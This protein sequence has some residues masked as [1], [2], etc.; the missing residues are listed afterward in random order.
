MG[1]HKAAGNYHAA[2]LIAHRYSSASQPDTGGRTN[3]QIRELQN[4]FRL[5]GD[6]GGTADWRTY[7]QSW[8]DSWN[9]HRGQST[10]TAKCPY[11]S[12]ISGD[13]ASLVGKCAWTDG[14]DDIFTEWST[15]FPIS[16]GSSRGSQKFTG[17]SGKF[18]GMSVLRAPEGPRI[19]CGCRSRFTA[20]TATKQTDFSGTVV[21]RSHEAGLR[22][23]W[24]LAEER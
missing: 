17:G 7:A 12:E 24:G 15:T 11:I 4:R 9:C 6:R 20:P 14:E 3:R 19:R 23:F 2:T 22:A 13:T 16:K 8:R 5:R 18:S 21:L 1:R 10:P